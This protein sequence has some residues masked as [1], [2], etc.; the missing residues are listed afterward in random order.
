MIFGFQFP[1]NPPDPTC[2]V[3]TGRIMLQYT[4]AKEFKWALSTLVLFLSVAVNFGH[5]ILKQIW[6]SCSKNSLL[7]RGS[8]FS[9][10][11]SMTKLTRSFR[12]RFYTRR[13]LHL[14]HKV[15]ILL[16]ECKKITNDNGHFDSP[17]QSDYLSI[18]Y[19]I[20]KTAQLHEYIEIMDFS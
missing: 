16:R 9:S 19:S 10:C 7:G 1:D 18:W 8:T 6:A 5:T 15:T 4:T 14:E 11:C 12:L 20:Q 2:G 3:E 17:S 13:T